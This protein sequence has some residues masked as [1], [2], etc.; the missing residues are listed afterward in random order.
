MSK[1]EVD[2]EDVEFYVYTLLGLDEDATDKQIKKAYHKL[3]MKCATPQRCPST[4]PAHAH[5][6]NYT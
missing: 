5:T 2:E 1:D 6:Y 4:A 3:S